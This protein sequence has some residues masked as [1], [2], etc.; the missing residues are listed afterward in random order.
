MLVAT[1]CLI[2]QMLQPWLLHSSKAEMLML[3]CQTL[4]IVCMNNVKLLRG[5][6]QEAAMSL[7]ARKLL[8][9]DEN[10]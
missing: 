1:Q 9:S 3:Q 8:N 6:Q 7:S 4:Q 2:L 10:M 5:V